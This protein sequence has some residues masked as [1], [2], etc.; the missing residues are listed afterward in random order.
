MMRVAC[1]NIT[2]T[3]WVGEESGKREGKRNLAKT[4]LGRKGTSQA[5]TA[6]Q[7]EQELSGAHFL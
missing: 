6:D 3:A 7:E 4:A 1:T 2:N 5:H